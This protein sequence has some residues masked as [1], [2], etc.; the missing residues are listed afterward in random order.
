MWHV[1]ILSWQT[2]SVLGGLPNANVNLQRFSYAISQ[3]AL[4]PPVVALNRNF[5]SQMAARYAAFSH[6]IPKSHW[7]L[8][9]SASKSQCF[10]S[11]RQQAN[12]TTSQTLALYKSHP[13]SAT[14]FLSRPPSRRPLLD[15]TDRF[16]D[17]GQKKQINFCDINSLSSHPKRPILD[18]Q[19]KSL[20]AS[21]PRKEH[22]RDPH[23]P[24]R[25]D[26]GGQERGPKRAF[27][28]HKKFS[29][30]FSS[31]PK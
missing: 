5:E 16:V 6:A 26:F 1:A 22:K 31:C 11:Q 17:R 21:F 13:S 8:S 20:C 27:L 15:F 29:L 24:F 9:F 23:K 19:K 3:I 7:P 12:A 14:K 25:G 2:L 28:G 10:T 30:L 18:P 4:L